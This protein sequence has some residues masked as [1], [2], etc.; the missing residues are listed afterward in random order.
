MDQQRRLVILTEAMSNDH[1]GKTAVSVIRYNTTE[2]IAILDSTNAGKC[3]QDLF[4]VGGNIPVIAQ[5]SEAQEATA[6]LIGIAPPGGTFPQAWRPIIKEALDRGLHIISGLHDFLGDDPEFSALAREHQVHIHDIRK[7]N[8]RQVATRLGINDSCYRVHTVGHDCS[9]GK[10]VTSLEIDKRMRERNIDSTFVA[11]GQTGIMITGTG[12]PMDCI[13]GD[14]LNG[15]GEE[16]VR[17]HQNHD[18]ML[19]EGQG[20]I[21]QPLYSPVTLG[22]LHGCMP[23]A[24]ILCY[25]TH[26]KQFTNTDIPIPPLQTFVNLYEH[27]SSAVHP[28][29]VVGVAMNSRGESDTFY[30]QE[31]QRIQNELQL[32]V[33]DVIRENA[34]VLVDALLSHKQEIGK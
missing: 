30:E 22:I 13:V 32:P 29:K 14:F 20:S 7:N 4:Q 11:T 21:I 18:V 2:V 28:C 33:T 17:Q 19:I 34:D 3:S 23:D 15:A 10:M 16:L 25:A 26:R 9:I 24:L 31:K 8:F 1:Q 5:L 27:I 12:L 6:L